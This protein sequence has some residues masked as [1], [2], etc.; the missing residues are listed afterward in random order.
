V[1]TVNAAILVVNTAQ[2]AVAVAAVNAAL[3]PATLNAALA[4]AAFTGY[5]VANYASYLV[6][7]FSATLTPTVATVNGVIA[8]AAVNVALTPVTLNAA[9]ADAA[10]TGY[11]AANYDAYFAATATLI[12]PVF[13]TVAAVNAAILVV[14]TEEAAIAAVNTATTSVTLNAAL[15]NT[16]FTGYAAGNATAYF[17]NIAL[18]SAVLTPTVALIN[19]AI[20]AVNTL[21]TAPTVTWSTTGNINGAID[22]AGETLVLTFSKAMV[23]LAI[24]AANIDTVLLPNHSKTHRDGA[25]AI[26]SATWL[27]GNTVLR[28]VY[29][30]ATLAPTI[31]AASADTI[32]AVGFTSAAGGVALVSVPAVLNTTNPYTVLTTDF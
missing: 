2:T 25:G 12:T 18:F 7:D 4:D 8:V 5:V 23:P 24:T 21:A 29:T 31:K 9:L 30:I 1:A 19:A 16:A 22:V 27:T 10:F 6:A 3:T 17:T 20:T 13:T 11:L 26:G 15:A 14:N 32:T 28:I